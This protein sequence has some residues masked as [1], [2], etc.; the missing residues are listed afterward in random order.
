MPLNLQDL[1]K[2]LGE[3]IERSGL[4]ALFNP[5]RPVLRCPFKPHKNHQFLAFFENPVEEKKIY[6]FENLS[7]LIEALKIK[8]GFV[9]DEI[10]YAEKYSIRY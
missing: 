9:I 10:E 7:A 2:L 4:D 1:L 6:D 5:I 8:T 3:L